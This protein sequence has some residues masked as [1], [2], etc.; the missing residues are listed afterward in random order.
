MRKLLN[1]INAYRL[2]HSLQV[3]WYVAFV[4][5]IP[6]HTK[7][8]RPKKWETQLHTKCCKQESVS[9]DVWVYFHFAKK[10]T[11]KIIFGKATF[12]TSSVTKKLHFSDLDK[13]NFSLGCLCGT[14]EKLLLKLKL[15]GILHVIIFKVWII[16]S[17]NVF[18]DKT[19]FFY[20]Y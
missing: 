14:T 15:K 2:Y 17:Q 20:L 4:C 3:M 11:S 10:P 19:T 18:R 16:Y 6:Q 1:D 13:G 9:S 5:L 8:V 12:P 7:H